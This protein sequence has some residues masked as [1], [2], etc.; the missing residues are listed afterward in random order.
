MWASGSV[1]MQACFMLAR[2]AHTLHRSER[3]GERKREKERER[4]REREKE[5]GR[6]RK[7]KREKER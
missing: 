6:K 5:R 4:E 1:G 3:V 7:R 2:V